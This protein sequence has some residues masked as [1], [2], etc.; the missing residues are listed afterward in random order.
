VLPQAFKLQLPVAKPPAKSADI[1]SL[2]KEEEVK[3]EPKKTE[4]VKKPEPKK[5]EAKPEVKKPEPKVKQPQDEKPKVAVKSGPVKL[6]GKA[7]IK[8]SKE[9]EVPVV[10]AVAQAE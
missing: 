8:K 5:P 2:I 6:T 3:E 9:D 4:P 1:I 10:N 7:P